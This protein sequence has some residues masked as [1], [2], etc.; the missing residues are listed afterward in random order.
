[1]TVIHCG[2]LGVDVGPSLYALLSVEEAVDLYYE[3]DG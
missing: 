3:K 1:M 2:V